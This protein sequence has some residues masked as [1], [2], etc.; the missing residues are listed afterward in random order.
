MLCYDMLH[1]HCSTQPL[2]RAQRRISTF[3]T[4]FDALNSCT[5]VLGR[6]S[7]SGEIV[8]LFG[9]SEYNDD[10]FEAHLAVAGMGKKRL[11]AAGCMGL[12]DKA[13]DTISLAMP[14]VTSLDLS[15]WQLTDA[16][17]H[18]LVHCQQLQVLVLNGCKG[19]GDAGLAA[20]GSRGGTPPAL[21]SLTSLDMG[22][23][24]EVTDEGV[25]CV[26]SCPLRDLN[27][28]LCSRVGA[29]AANPP[30]HDIGAHWGMQCTKLE[31]VN[32]TGTAADDALMFMLSSNAP[33]LRWVNLTRC[34]AVGDEGVAALAANGTLLSI[35]I[36]CTGTTD[37]SL[38]TI[39]KSCPA[40]RE[41][42]CA[43]C[44]EM[45]DEGFQAFAGGC[46]QQLMKLVVDDCAITDVAM[47]AMCASCPRLTD[48]QA[49][50]CNNITDQTVYTLV[51]GCSDLQ[52][53]DLRGCNQVTSDAVEHMEEHLPDCSMLAGGQRL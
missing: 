20:F 3:S 50:G 45:S 10:D 26:V 25:A 31:R 46:V 18:T 36:A 17:L 4:P 48:V 21:P 16:A 15:R 13:V 28:Q 38:A 23:C 7:T 44:R 53:L 22:H 43:G 1:R 33:S 11:V 27:L 41:L 5:A 47:C 6:A 30:G 32:L 34:A 2:P 9:K 19:F 39:G 52:N 24:S 35:Y 51:D 12:G 29:S 8:D 49:V 42:H 37:A 40:L 14:S